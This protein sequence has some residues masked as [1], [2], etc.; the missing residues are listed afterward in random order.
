MYNATL[1]DHFENPR[2][3]GEIPSPSVDVEVTNPACGDIL[4]LSL[5]I[6]PFGA[7]DARIAEARFKARGCAPTI[8]CGSML[9][10]LIRGKTLEQA[11]RTSLAD[12][13]SG[14]GGLPP[15]SGHAAQLATDALQAALRQ[16]RE[17]LI[18]QQAGRQQ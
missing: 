9:T 1:L 6:V 7:A 2:N 18:R 3:A 10:E 8:A 12:I 14:L 17:F 13:V 15:E 4:R 11:A 5:S 16:A